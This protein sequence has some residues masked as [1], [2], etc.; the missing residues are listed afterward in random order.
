LANLVQDDSLNQNFLNQNEIEIEN[1]TNPENL[2]LEDESQYSLNLDNSQIMTASEEKTQFNS[3]SGYFYLLISGDGKTTKRKIQV[4]FNSTDAKTPQTVTIK[5]CAVSGYSDNHNL[6][7]LNSTVKTKLAVNNYSIVTMQLSYTKPAHY[8]AE[9]SILNKV[10]DHRFNFRKYNLENT[11]DSTV[12]NIGHVSTNTT[13]TVDLQ[14]NLANCGITLS[15][16]N[17]T[18][19]NA[20]GCIELKKEYYSLLKIDPN[21]GTHSGKTSTYN[22]GT[23]LCA[24][25]V[26]IKNPT[27]QG[28][29]FTGW[30]LSKGSYCT[31]AIFNTLSNNFTYCGK[32][33]TNSNVSS[34]NTCVLKANWKIIYGTITIKSVDSKNNGL[35][36]S[37]YSIY[38]N[39]GKKLQTLQTDEAGEVTFTQLPVGKYK[40]YEDKIQQSFEL[41]K[42][43]A[44]ELEITEEKTD[45]TFEI[46]HNEKMVLP[47]TGGISEDLGFVLIGIILIILNKKRRIL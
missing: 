3:K 16:N 30:N 8:I 19:S 29:Q 17:Y 21:G 45:I 25:V 10:Y 18:A 14:I 34:S 35:K 31:G 6:K 20:T 40:I 46:S 42:T 15:T 9:G 39:S 5:E 11:G 33:T 1:S 24:T 37:K 4:T 44:I 28:Y 36:G 13:E 27:R 26:N 32:S 12:N 22:Y 7:I 41:I 47:E 38:N 2:I 23:K 43:N